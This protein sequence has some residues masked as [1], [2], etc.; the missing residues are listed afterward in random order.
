MAVSISFAACMTFNEEH[1]RTWEL[2]EGI[3]PMTASGIAGDYYN[4]RSDPN[5]PQPFLWTHLMMKP[6]TSRTDDMVRIEQVG[7]DRLRFLLMRS[8]VVIDSAEE[9]CERRATHMRLTRNRIGG[10]PPVL[11]TLVSSAIA[12]GANSDGR[13]SVSRRTGGAAFL[14]I[15]PWGAGGIPSAVNYRRTL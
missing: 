13:L 15:I 11:W 1:V 8:G 9:S 3:V 10:A 4:R 6:D 5:T 12:L 2:N 14:V 7:P